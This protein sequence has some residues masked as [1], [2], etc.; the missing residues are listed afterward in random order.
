MA[1]PRA[2]LIGGKYLGMPDFR[3]V[4]SET[5]RNDAAKTGITSIRVSDDMGQWVE[6]RKGIKELSLRN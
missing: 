3:K 4:S 6:I 1:Q 2:A 5:L